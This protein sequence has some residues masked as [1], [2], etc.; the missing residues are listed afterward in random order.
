MVP[1]SA[2][3][4]RFRSTVGTRQAPS[5]PGV[6]E[7]PYA[8]AYGRR[9]GW[10][11]RRSVMFRNAAE[12][13]DG[14]PPGAAKPPATERARRLDRRTA[15]EHNDG[16]GWYVRSDPDQGAG[17]RDGARGR[18]DPGRRAVPGGH[19]VRPVCRAG[20]LL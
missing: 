12:G 11:P 4:T 18:D 7:L 20:A 3:I 14:A 6:S 15:A 1:P 16:R 8:R 2:G 13:G 10:G 17:P 19:G 5:Q 9:R